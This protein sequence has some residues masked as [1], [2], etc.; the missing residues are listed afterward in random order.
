M[1]VFTK[2][3]QRVLFIH[4]PKTAGSSVTKLFLQNGYE[5]SYYSESS[6]EPYKGLCGPQHM[7]AELLKGEFDLS[8]F[9]YIFSVFRDPVDRHLSE[10]TWAPW[11][12]CGQNLYSADAFEHWVPQ[13]FEAYRRE[14]Y[15]FDNHIRPQNEFYVPGT[16]VYDYE[17][18]G[19][20]AGKLCAKLGMSNDD[21]PYER[22]SRRDDVE[23][24]MYAETFYLIEEFYDGDYQWLK[25]S[26]LL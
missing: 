18:I 7:D 10:F 5:R 17:E 16:E 20:L 13:I 22:S 8:D 24:D 25:D 1:P 12:L 14:N 4:V 23:Y 3:N 19:S 6:A 2:G 9:D 21:L 26:T 11:G 15:R